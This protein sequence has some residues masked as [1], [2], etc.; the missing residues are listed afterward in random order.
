VFP[1]STIAAVS[2]LA[3]CSPDREDGAAAAMPAGTGANGAPVDAAPPQQKVLD[4]LVGSQWRLIELAGAEVAEDSN[5][6]LVFYEP[7]RLA[8]NGSV[9]R[10]NGGI[11]VRDGALEV[12]PLASTMMAGP[13]DAMEREQ[14]YLAALQ[15]AAAL[16][17]SQDDVL[18]ITL[19]D[20]EHPLKFR[21]I[22]QPVQ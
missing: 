1:I 4:S 10:F 19:R 6:D 7:G 20:R 15:V 21:R 13:P 12:S 11:S 9:N 2:M 5:A 17:V 8:G 16:V 18:T 22:S 3:A 14:Q